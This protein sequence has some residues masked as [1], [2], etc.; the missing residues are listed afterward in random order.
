MV[1][2]ER[3]KESCKEEDPLGLDL[4]RGAVLGR[5]VAPGAIQDIGESNAVVRGWVWSGLSAL[6]E[7]RSIVAEEGC[8]GCWLGGLNHDRGCWLTLERW[9][10]WVKDC[11]SE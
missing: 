6:L 1:W 11:W 5:A 4:R 10:I 8:D 3:E 2:V 9:L 7:A